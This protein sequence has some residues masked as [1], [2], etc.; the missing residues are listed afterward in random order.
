MKCPNCGNDMQN[1]H[2]ICESCGY[3]IQMVPDFDPEME[4]DI[5]HNLIDENSNKGNVF[6]D[7]NDQTLDRPT[8][9]IITLD[10]VK[11]RI[12]ST[13]GITIIAIAALV[14]VIVSILHSNR[15]DV[16]LDNIKEKANKGNY[17]EAISGLENLHVRNPGVSEIFFL[18]SD[19]Y[20]QLNKQEMAIDTLM[21]ILSDGRF[22]EEDIYKSYDKIIAIY[23]ETEEYENINK[24]LENC[25]YP[26]IVT[27]YQNY[28]AM[29]PTFSVPGGEYED[30]VRIKLSANT[31]GVIYYTLDGSVPNSESNK[32]EGTI[33]LGTGYYNVSAMFINQY[34]IVSDIVTETYN[35]T[36]QAP[37]APIVNFESGNYDKP[38]L[39]EVEIPENSTVFYTTDK[40]K[41]T[42][43]SIPYTGPIPMPL[44][45]SNF[46][47][48]AISEEGLTSDVVVRS[49]HLAC[50]DSI[51]TD[52][53]VEIL[54]KRMVERGMLNDMSGISNRAPGKYTYA[55]SS[56]V[57]IEGQ[58]DYY[59]INEFYNDE[60]GNRSTSDT[61]YLVEIKQGSTGI[62][63]GD[64]SFG[65]IALAF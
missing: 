56:A 52:K 7:D 30:V 8:E 22:S 55:A 45:Y 46:N 62:L 35:V 16:K 44:N 59:I 43:D 9:P 42:I 24:L 47:F 32:Y 11:K 63:G 28:L 39:I 12:F 23:A 58:G 31:S 61:T 13:I 19:Y 3:E 21:R 53:A 64:A 33:E 65:F 60:S 54:K 49:Y 1:G 17:E 27:S 36:A 38:M 29:P 26:E 18:E 5:D 4:I 15:L 6:S 14:V 41:P 10:L 2:L 50:A 20:M 57:H 34:G 51:S 25:A 48:V 37:D 40:S